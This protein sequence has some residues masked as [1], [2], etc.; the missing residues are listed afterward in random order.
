MLTKMFRSRTLSDSIS[1]KDCSLR[2]TALPESG[3]LFHPE[4]LK[5]DAAN[6]Y[7][8]SHYA[9]QIV[10][11][12]LDCIRK[13]ADQCTGMQGF[14]IIHSLP[15]SQISSSKTIGGGDDSFNMFFSETSSGKHAR[16][17]HH[18]C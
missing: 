1:P 10:D 6:N 13:L 2:L 12:V 8:H 9:I 7:A 18:L 16:A 3:Q 4:Q 11:L 17:P 15:G 14:L 5:E